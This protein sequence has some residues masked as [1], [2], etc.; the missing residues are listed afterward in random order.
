MSEFV[1]VKL[2]GDNRLPIAFDC[3]NNPIPDSLRAR[4][5]ALGLRI[6]GCACGDGGCSDKS[7]EDWGWLDRILKQE[8]LNE[9]QAARDDT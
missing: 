7:N 9:T 6:L 3:R 2:A 8:G 4:C 5:D 1:E